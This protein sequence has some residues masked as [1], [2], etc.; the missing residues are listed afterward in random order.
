MHAFHYA[1]NSPN[2]TVAV[3]LDA[4]KAFDRIECAYLFRTLTEFGIGPQFIE[5]ISLLYKSPSA[6][7]C[8]NGHISDAFPLYRGTGQGCVVSPLLFV[9]SLEPLACLI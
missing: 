4:E 7:I 9:L 2:P 3:S 5:N 6:K 8:T 1:N